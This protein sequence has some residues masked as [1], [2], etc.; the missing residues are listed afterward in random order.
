MYLSFDFVSSRWRINVYDFTKSAVQ[1]C[2]GIGSVKV[3]FNMA[4]HRRINLFKNP[5]L[6]G[7]NYDER[8]ESTGA[9]SKILKPTNF[10]V[11]QFG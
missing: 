7:L 4:C 10:F 2:D 9:V 8:I 6:I 5:T 3:R 1:V 11:G